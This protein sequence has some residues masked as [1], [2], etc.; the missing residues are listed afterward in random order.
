MDQLLQIVQGILDMGATV[1]LPVMITLMGLFFRMKF[2]DALKAGLIVSIGFAGLNLVLNMLF[3]VINPA[4]EYYSTMGS[5]FSVTDVPWPILGGAYWAAPFAA[6]VVPVGVTLNLL[7]LRLTKLNVINVDIWN[8]IHFLGAGTL[9]WALFGS[10]WLG[11][12][13]SVALSVLSL[14]VAQ[15][16]TTRWQEYFGLEGT[17]CSTLIFITWVW[18]F[19]WLINK[20]IDY[21]PGLNKLDIKV[22]EGESRWSILGDPVFIGLLVGFL[23]AVLTKQTYTTVLSMMVGT[24]AVMFLM[25]RMVGVLM[26]GLSSIGAAV[27]EY[28]QKRT[29]GEDV[30]IGMDVAIG[31]GDTCAITSSIL[32]MPIIIGLAFV[33]PNV[34]FFPL[35][36]LFAVPYFA[37]FTSMT[38]K[39]N[40]LRSLISITILMIM[41]MVAGTVFQPEWNT[42]LVTAGA[43]VAG[44]VTASG[45]DP[46]SFVIIMVSR[47][48]GGG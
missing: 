8:Y 40:L 18:P 26:E 35:G 41:S 15:M 22:K 34:S 5:G 2:R 12:L 31:L 36:L 32:A 39:G 42:M 37:V 6:L 20:I 28:I 24:A 47:L 17:T 9:A 11:F 19:T 16:V 27:R 25:P 33:V 30:V 48:L 1:I 3:E 46:Y 43:D 14:Y 21:I 13:I 45:F 10:F 38:A 7:L 23:L 44:E 29:E 4:I